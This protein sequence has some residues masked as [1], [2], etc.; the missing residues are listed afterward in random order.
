VLEDSAEEA[1]NLG[2]EFIGTEHLLL[3][4]VREVGSETER[5][6]QEVGL[7]IEML[8]DLVIVLLEQSDDRGEQANDQA[9]TVFLFAAPI[10]APPPAGQSGL[11]KRFG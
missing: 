9:F 3:S 2:H 8:R 1:R 5:L 4:C 10:F 7:T 6:L 11:S